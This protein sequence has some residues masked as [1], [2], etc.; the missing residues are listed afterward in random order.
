[1]LH[2]GT[3]TAQAVKSKK[4]RSRKLIKNTFIIVML[5]YPVAH[6]LLMW[7][8]VN[9]DALLLSFQRYYLLREVDGKVEFV[10]EYVFVGLDNYRLLL[11]SIRIQ[12]NIR[13]MLFN[14]FLYFPVTCFLSIPLASAFSYFLF[15]KVPASNLFRVLFFLPAIMPVVVMTMVFKFSFND[16]FGFVNPALKSLGISNPPIWFGQKPWARITVFM[17]CIWAGLG[18]NIVLLSGAMGRVP[19]EIIEY[20]KIEGI[21]MFRE[22]RSVM[23][24]LIWP[25]ITT[26]FV[27]GMTSVLTVF[28]QPHFL[29]EGG[30]GTNTIS[31]N[32]YVNTL[33]GEKMT[34]SA[35]L[36][37]F[38][39]AIFVPVILGV[40]K[41][42]SKLYGD[43]DY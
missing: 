27:L 37:L 15:K 13:E 30:L 22:F 29:T 12:R 34:D 16:V 41:L 1:M 20:G 38:A 43:V 2:N 28:M 26:L 8:Y 4:P 3:D 32:I 35:T 21:G 10:N 7:V 25:T 33:K 14:S 40:R 19:H 31:L 24:P 5:A 36:G 11:Q 6:F 17:Y 42:M 39:T 9:I 23:I 18:Y